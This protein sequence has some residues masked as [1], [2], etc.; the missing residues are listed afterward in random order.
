MR[1]SERPPSLNLSVSAI[2][3]HFL[4]K[5]AVFGLTNDDFQP[6]NGVC[7]DDFFEI[8]VFLAFVG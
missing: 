3:D 4:P 8:Q 6:T 2:F 1:C 7:Q 5:I